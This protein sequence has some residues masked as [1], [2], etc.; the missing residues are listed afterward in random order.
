MRAP[1][2]LVV[3]DERSV[4]QSVDKILR[5]RGFLIDQALEVEAALQI[6]ERGERFDLVVADLM[7]PKAGGVELLKQVRATWPKLPVLLITG[8][9][10]IASAVEV[11]QLG[12]AGYLPKPFTP[13][14]LEEAVGAVLQKNP[15]PAADAD[16]AAE[17]VFGLDVG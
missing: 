11:M 8:Y 16:G 3:D 13:E 6:L 4:C 12:A 2:V 5:R 9:A 17:G 14:E 7:M 10:S 1:R 15:A